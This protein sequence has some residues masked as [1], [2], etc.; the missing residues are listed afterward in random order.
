MPS[1]PIPPARP[2]GRSPWPRVVVV[3]IILAF[4]TAMTALG[5]APEAAAGVAAAVLAAVGVTAT[6]DLPSG[7]A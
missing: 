5:Y 7:Q 2:R 4:V 1:Y 3:I 6:G